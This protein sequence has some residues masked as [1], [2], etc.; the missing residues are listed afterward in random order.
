MSDESTILVK[1]DDK[2]SVGIPLIDEQHKELIRLTNELYQGCLAGDATAYDFFFNT[3]RKAMNYVKY[4]FSAEEKILE[5]IKYPYLAEH[6]KQHED[7]VLKMVEDVKSF[8]KGK[9]FVPNNFVRFLKE[10]IL[11][12]I[13]IVDTQYAKY[14][15]S[16][17]KQGKL[18]G[19]LGS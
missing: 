1:W 8:Q 14:I 15:I 13:A 12:H 17:K 6:K 2:Y 7:F 19:V 9:K 3:I 16:L 18:P 11:S 5:N 10:W 4:H